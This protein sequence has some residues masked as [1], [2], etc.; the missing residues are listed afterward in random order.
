MHRHITWPGN[1]NAVTSRIRNAPSRVVDPTTSCLFV[2]QR[3]YTNFR[4]AE[5]T[6]GK[7]VSRFLLTLPL[8]LCLR[9]GSI[10]F[11]WTGRITRFASD[12]SDPFKSTEDPG[13]PLEEGI[14]LV[15]S[16]VL[17]PRD[18][19]TSLPADPGLPETGV[20]IFGPLLPITASACALHSLRLAP[21]VPAGREGPLH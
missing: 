1:P 19:S 5:K 4:E 18:R 16:S 11:Q 17:R 9:C 6:E 3:Y 15:T 14:E 2:R 21:P 7:A 10:W 13:Q 8:L 12:C 20:L